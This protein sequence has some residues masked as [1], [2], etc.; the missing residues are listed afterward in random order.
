MDS[1]QA[2]FYLNSSLAHLL[3]EQNNRLIITHLLYH[4]LNDRH[5]YG[6]EL[7]QFYKNIAKKF[8]ITERTVGNVLRRLE[9]HDVIERTFKGRGGV[10]IKLKLNAWL[11]A[12]SLIKNVPFLNYFRGKI[13][14]LIINNKDN[15]AYMH[16]VDK[17]CK[18]QVSPKKHLRRARRHVDGEKVREPSSPEGIK[19]IAS[20]A[21]TRGISMD[22]IP[23]LMAHIQQNIHKALNPGAWV[24]KVI[25]LF[26]ENP[27]DFVV[28]TKTHYTPSQE[29]REES[30]Q[31]A[32]EMA[33]Q[34]AILHNQRL[35][36][37]H[38]SPG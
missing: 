32:D 36:D 8:A 1:N 25:D 26:K 22:G 11:I 3:N 30:R 33:M 24:S 7:K 16:A 17:S 13:R 21:L 19:E 20:Q 12:N 4:T 6:P 15:N 5:R 35:Y 34:A 2:S 28:K 23:K 14:H 38:P 9:E 29:E 18:R 31:K 27:D 10:Y 37:L